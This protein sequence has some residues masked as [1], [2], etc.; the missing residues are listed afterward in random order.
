MPTKK[1]LVAK[2]EDAAKATQ[3]ATP[4]AGAGLVAIP[5]VLIEYIGPKPEH[6][7]DTGTGIVWTPGAVHAITRE[8]AG[9]LLYYTDCWRDARPAEEA[10]ADPITVLKPIDVRFAKPD[11]PEERDLAPRPPLDKLTKEGLRV[12]AMR[13]FQQDLPETMTEPAMREK[14]RNLAFGKRYEYA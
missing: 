10:A 7:E 6:K 1:K 11:N 12:Y 4:L 9:F 3:A 5:K 13:N 2:A 8:Q 14:L